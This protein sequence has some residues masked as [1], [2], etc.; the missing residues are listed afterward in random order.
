MTFRPCPYCGGH[1]M[2]LATVKT[3]LPH[4]GCHACH[5]V[6]VLE[7]KQAF[8]CPKPQQHVKP[9]DRSGTIP[10][11]TIN[12]LIPGPHSMGLL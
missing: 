1:L 12:P 6:F 5:T 4:Y 8:P 11:E 9:W 10:T 2:P 3:C 7:M